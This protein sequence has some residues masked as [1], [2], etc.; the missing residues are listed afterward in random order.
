MEIRII[1]LDSQVPTKEI[2]TSGT[3]N[4]YRVI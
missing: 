4:I 1:K 3:A 2:G